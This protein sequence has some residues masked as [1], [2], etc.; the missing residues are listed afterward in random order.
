MHSVSRR[1]RISLPLAGLALLAACS[2]VFRQPEVQLQSVRVGGIGLRGA[3]LV[4]QLHI[5]NPNSFGL[6][7][8]SFTYDLQLRDG[9][10]SEEWL[11]LASGTIDERIQV[12]GRSS[13]LVEIPIEFAYSDFGPAVR[14]L[15]DRGT[16]DY[17]VSGRVEV[18][19]PMSRSVPYRK[20]GKVTLQGV[21]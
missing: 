13:K 16:F 1:I 2:S 11:P 20:S 18:R 15:L 21:R 4:A 6:E 3:T 17:R 9:D 8:R 19:E 7:T 10:R 5:D 12:D 14:S